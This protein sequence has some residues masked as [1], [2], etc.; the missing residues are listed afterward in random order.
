MQNPSKYQVLNTPSSCTIKVQAKV[1][2]IVLDYETPRRAISLNCLSGFARCT[3]S[4]RAQHRQSVCP[5]LLSSHFSPSYFPIFSPHSSP[6]FASSRRVLV[7]TFSYFRPSFH[8]SSRPIR[9]SEHRRL[10]HK[11]SEGASPR[12]ERKENREITRKKTKEEE[13]RALRRPQF[14]LE[15]TAWISISQ[16][17][18]STGRNLTLPFHVYYHFRFSKHECAR[19]PIPPNF[20]QNR[21]HFSRIFPIFKFLN[22]SR[23]E[24]P[25]FLRLSR[26]RI[27]MIHSAKA[28]KCLFFVTLCGF[29]V[30]RT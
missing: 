11:R 10:R 27:A 4:P 1:G 9:E 20:S 21:F 18:L 6:H 26:I 25:E 3:S 2:V 5:S 29:C 19:V 24:I 16:F 28:C 17:P 14:S 30:R 23:S 15:H 8:F 13:A 7:F 22:L 12:G